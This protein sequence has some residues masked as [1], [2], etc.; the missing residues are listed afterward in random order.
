L[1]NAEP[2]VMNVDSIARASPWEKCSKMIE[3]LKGRYRFV[4]PFQGFDLL[5][6]RNSQAVGLGY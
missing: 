2:S 3:A 1:A 6:E 5:H 4:S